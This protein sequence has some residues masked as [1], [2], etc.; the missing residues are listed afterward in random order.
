M[1]LSVVGLGGRPHPESGEMTRLVEGARLA[2]PWKE[3]QLALSQRQ[4]GP[5]QSQ[6]PLIAPP[7]AGP[8][9][10]CSQA[11]C[12]FRD[13]PPTQEGPNV[14]PFQAQFLSHLYRDT[15]ALMCPTPSYVLSRG[16]YPVLY[17]G[18]GRDP[19]LAS[20]HGDCLRRMTVECPAGGAQWK[21]GTLSLHSSLTKP[22]RGW[23]WPAGQ[24]REGAPLGSRVITP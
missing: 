7:T 6:P 1:W 22:G 15:V 5:Q 19:S 9:H 24:M 13:K 17:A 4:P 21:A 11:L 23:P 2:Q 3:G 10:S 16:V 20:H 18:P 8:Q 14:P 12:C